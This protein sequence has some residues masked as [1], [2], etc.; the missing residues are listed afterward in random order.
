MAQY[1][2]ICVGAYWFSATLISKISIPGK[3]VLI[4]RHGTDFSSQTMY[5]FQPHVRVFYLRRQ[6]DIVRY[7]SV[8]TGF[9]THDRTKCPDGRYAA[10]LCPRPAPIPGHDGHRSLRDFPAMSQQATSPYENCRLL[11]NTEDFPDHTDVAHHIWATIVGGNYW[12]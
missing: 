3:M 11:I 12:A 9:V 8:K 2:C 6:S 7:F 1:L 10:F 4:L 5:L